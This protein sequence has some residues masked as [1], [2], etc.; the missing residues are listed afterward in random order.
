MHSTERLHQELRERGY[1]GSLRT[2]RRF[3]SR[4]RQDS[5]IP[6]ATSR[7]GG[8]EGGREPCTLTPPSKLASDDRSALAQITARCEE[9]AATQALVREFADMLG[10]RHG[11]HLETRAS[12]A[13][14][15]PVSELRGFT[16]GLRKDWAAVTAARPCPTAPARSRATSTASR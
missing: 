14:N 9:L 16:K 13:E 6:A 10:H 5:A 8:Q 12:Q 11:E 4:L 7:T 1:R 2:L 15:S 3:T